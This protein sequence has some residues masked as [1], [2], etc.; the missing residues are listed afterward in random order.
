MLSTAKA[1]DAAD[2]ADAANDVADI[3]AA[4]TADMAADAN[5]HD[6]E[7]HYIPVTPTTIPP[8]PKPPVIPPS[9]AK[10]RL[11][12]VFLKV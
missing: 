11:L 9:N 12:K 2:A 7:K 8:T 6:L 10:I 5:S 1:S 4:D 3:D